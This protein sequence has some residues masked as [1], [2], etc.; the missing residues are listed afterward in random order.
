[1][2]KQL[3]TIRFLTVL[4][5]VSMLLITGCRST[6]PGGKGGGGGDTPTMPKPAEDPVTYALTLAAA[7]ADGGVVTDNTNAGPYAEGAKINVTATANEGYNFV[8]W[9]VDGTVVSDQATFEYTMP[10]K[11]VTLTANFAKQVFFAGTDIVAMAG[12][13]GLSAGQTYPEKLTVGG[14]EIS[15]ADAVY[16]MAKVLEALADSGA[17]NVEG[18]VLGKLPDFVPYKQI[19]LPNTVTQ[20]KTDGVITWENIFA[21]AR[22]MVNT[23]DANPQ[24]PDEITVL[25]HPS[26]VNWAD[27]KNMEPEE[28]TVGI[29]ILISCYARMIT[30][31]SNNNWQ[32][33]NFATIKGGVLPDSW[34]QYEGD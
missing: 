12:N 8:N 34:P 4:L 21:S 30:Y 11:D 27:V 3:R 31:A 14:N 2:K 33:A 7:P 29:N 5:L 24:I 6:K 28:Q 15:L 9:T 18:G 25:W 26:G 10:A 19:A 13:L 22:Q 23:L 1:M 17:T 20:G 16:L 32:F